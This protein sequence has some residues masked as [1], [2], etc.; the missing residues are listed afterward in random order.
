VTYSVFL[1]KKAEKELSKIPNEFSKSIISEAK[2]LSIDPKSIGKK[3]KPTE[4]YRIRVGDYR[5]IYQIQEAEKK[6]VILLVGYRSKIYYD[7][8][9]LK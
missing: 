6:V 4:Y 1:H 8:E 9:Q 7:F 2:K 3:L 5:A